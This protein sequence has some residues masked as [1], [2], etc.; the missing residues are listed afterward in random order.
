LVTPAL[1]PE[2]SQGRIATLNKAI[3]LYFPDHILTDEDVLIDFLQNSPNYKFIQNCGKHTLWH[4]LKPFTPGAQPPACTEIGQRWVSPID[5]ATLMCVPAGEFLMGASETDAQAGRDEQPQHRVY[6]DAFWIDRTEVT[7]ANFAQC[8]ADGVC[9]PR[10][11]TPYS[12][13]VSSIT[14]LDYYE[15]LA[16][17]DYPVL[18]FDAAEAQTYCQWAGRRLP[19]EA[20]WEKAARGPDERIF[21]WGNELDCSRASYLSCTEDTT[22]VDEP[23]VGASP[24]GV[25]NLAGN[26]W[27]WVADWYDPDYYANSPDKNPAGPETGEHKVRRGGGWR[28]LAKDLRVTNRA[29]GKA[30]HYFDGQMGFRCAISAAAPVSSSIGK[31]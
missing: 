18:M 21:P 9:H 17:A 14:R 27:E 20:E 19:S 10:R 6:L 22:V 16:Y 13:G 24:Y 2:L 4:S 29:S 25:L 8:V 15:N 5:G 30:H 11:Y 23:Q 26:V 12:S 28:S 3:E 31:Q 7:N 1:L